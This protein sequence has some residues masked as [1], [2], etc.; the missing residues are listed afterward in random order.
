MNYEIGK[1]YSWFV[2]YRHG[3]AAQFAYPGNR[4][5]RLLCK[6]GKVVLF[7]TCFEAIA[8]AQAQVRKVCE[9]DIRAVTAEPEPVPAFLDTKAWDDERQIKRAVERR[10]VFQGLGKKSV[11]VETR[12]RGA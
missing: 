7:A 6:D 8:A 4:R 10:S 3:Y 5:T 12:R 11:V 9:P 2:Q 1:S